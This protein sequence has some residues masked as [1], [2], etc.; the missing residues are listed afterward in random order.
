MRLLSIL[1]LVIFIIALITEPTHRKFNSYL[2]KKG[3][4]AGTC[5]GGTRHVSYKIFSIDYVTYCN[6]GKRDTVRYVGVFGNFLKN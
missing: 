6:N 4:N 2:A 3:K 5:L 1:L